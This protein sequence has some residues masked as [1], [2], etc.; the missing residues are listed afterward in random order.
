MATDR[1]YIAMFSEADKEAQ[2]RRGWYFKAVG[3]NFP[4]FDALHEPKSISDSE[5]IA[6]AKELF[7]ATEVEVIR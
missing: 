1:K 5:I 7:G 6:F 4:E 3:A 2:V